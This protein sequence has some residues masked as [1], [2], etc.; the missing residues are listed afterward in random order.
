MKI[1]KL[2]VQNSHNHQGLLC[3][4]WI[5]VAQCEV[6]EPYSVLAGL[7]GIVRATI[8]LYCRASR[9][10]QEFLPTIICPIE[11]LTY[12]IL[13]LENFEICQLYKNYPPYAQPPSRGT[14]K[15]VNPSTTCSGFSLT[16]HL[17]QIKILI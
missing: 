10:V 1:K 11:I 5:L 4:H 12:R 3:P 7:P 8:I 14:P 13:Y 15:I 16:D 17:I 9:G 6:I 2:I